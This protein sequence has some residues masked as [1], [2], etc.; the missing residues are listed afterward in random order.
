MTIIKHPDGTRESAH[1]ALVERVRVIVAG[2][3]YGLGEAACRISCECRDR[4][5]AA[6]RE[7]YL[8]MTEPTPEMCKAAAKRPRSEDTNNLY[9]DIWSAMLS[10]SPLN[11]G[12]NE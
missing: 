1:E 5:R 7:A 3:C 11:G 10:A 9:A 6:L 4:T 8:A 2:D 12:T